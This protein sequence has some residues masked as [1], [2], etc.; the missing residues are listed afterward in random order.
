M[1]HGRPRCA[2]T[3][4]LSVDTDGAF[5]EYVALPEVDVWK[6]DPTLSTG[7][8]R[9]SGT[10]GERHRYGAGRRRGGQKGA[11]HGLRAYWPPGPLVSPVPPGPPVSVLPKSVRFGASLLSA[12]AP[13]GCSTRWKGTWSRP[14]VQRP[15]AMG[16]TSCSKCRAMRPP[17]GRVS[18]PSHRAAGVPAGPVRGPVS[19]DLNTAVILKD[20]RLY[21]ITGR[22]IFATWYKAA[23]FFT[24]WA[25]RS[26]AHHHAS[27]ATGGVRQGHGP[28][29]PRG[30]WQ[31]VAPPWSRG[32][33]LALK[34]MGLP[35]RSH[36]SGSS[37][38]WQWGAHVRAAVWS[39]SVTR[40]PLTYVMNHKSSATAAT[41]HILRIMAAPT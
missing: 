40:E 17:S 15:T 30:V 28:D 19:L 9:H 3:K 36:S 35:S 5:A 26:L 37:S 12:W 18:R 7:M 10:T 25:A 34:Y 41:H 29:R 2:D 1:P 16:W 31:G 38:P 22:H 20:V 27:L 6:N 33:R 8:D 23:R 4:I 13:P 21:G 24:V 14:C 11:G 39:A 32:V